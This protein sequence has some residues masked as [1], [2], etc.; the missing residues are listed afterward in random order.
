MKR[1]KAPLGK[2][3]EI[4]L[5]GDCS[6]CSLYGAGV[7]GALLFAVPLQRTGRRKSPVWRMDYPRGN[8]GGV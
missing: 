4:F 2:Y 1:E 8:Y 5:A 7:S 3:V 6:I